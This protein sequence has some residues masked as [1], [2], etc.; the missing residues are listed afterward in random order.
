MGPTF[1]AL[2]LAQCPQTCLP[3]PMK[4]HCSYCLLHAMSSQYPFLN[5]AVSLA[6]P[7]FLPSF[8]CF[9][10]H[11]D[12]HQS[13]FHVTVLLAIVKTSSTPRK[14][15][16]NQSYLMMFGT[17]LHCVWCALVSIVLGVPTL[18]RGSDK[19]RGAQLSCKANCKG[20]IYPVEYLRSLR[21]SELLSDSPMI[22][23]VQDRVR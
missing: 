2:R 19:V 16:E 12:D 4:A 5:Q 13:E 9:Q 1:L 23:K 3:H 11:H 22:R 17:W 8:N 14:N 18:A 6:S 20:F 21:R 10:Y 7:A 15:S